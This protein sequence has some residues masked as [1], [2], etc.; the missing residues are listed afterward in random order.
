M[1]SK[2][3]TRLPANSV[4][5]S[6]E[7]ISMEDTERKIVDLADSAQTLLEAVH[8]DVNEVTGEARKPIANLAKTLRGRTVLAG[9]PP[10]RFAA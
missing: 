1:G 5:P 2:D 10:P 3:A 4:I 9:L 8:T 6:L 7:T